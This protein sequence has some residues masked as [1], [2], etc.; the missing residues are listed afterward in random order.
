M[1]LLFIGNSITAGNTGVSFI[2]I[3]KK[4]QPSWKIVNKG[5]N[6]EPLYNIADRLIR[7][8]KTDHAFDY[9]IIEAGV[10][11]LLLPE[12]EKRG[13]LYKWA[14]GRE[15]RYDIRPLSDLNRFRSFYSVLLK[16]ARLYTRARM[17]LVNIHRINEA[18]SPHF[19]RL[20]RDYNDVI[21]DLAGQ[22]NYRLADVSTAFEEVLDLDSNKDYL[23]RNFWNTN[24]WD[25]LRCKIP[26][27]ADQLS[28]KRDLKLTIDGVHLNSRGAR[29]YAQTVLATLAETAEPS[30]KTEFFKQKII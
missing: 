17:I 23:C 24:I 28:R 18:C 7:L 9:I 4:Q 25:G 6:G 8:L 14:I 30:F 2:R 12:L 20:Q 1:R 21:A 16:E 5:I 10:N 11:D 22:A 13:G 27:Q 29:L 15:R 26:G 3:I 19:L